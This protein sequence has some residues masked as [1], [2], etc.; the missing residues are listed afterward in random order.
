MTKNDFEKYG[1]RGMFVKSI[2]FLFVFFLCAGCSVDERY[3]NE[4][5]FDSNRLDYYVVGNKSIDNGHA[6]MK[7]GNFKQAE[8]CFSKAIEELGE[9]AYAYGFRGLA[10]YNIGDIEGALADLNKAIKL[11]NDVSD[12]YMWR[13]ETYRSLNENE[14]M[15]TDFKKA[16]ELMKNL[17]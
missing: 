6:N 9:N 5:S 13:A 2:F 10:K 14:A 15:E 17:G 11:K 16:K 3:G 4:E 7:A 1:L 12:F 8:K